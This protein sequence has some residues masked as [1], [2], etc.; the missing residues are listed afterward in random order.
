MRITRSGLR[1]IIAEEHAR[2]LAEMKAPKR[3]EDKTDEDWA[4]EQE[5]GVMDY[6]GDPDPY[7]DDEALEMGYEYDG[8]GGWI[9][10]DHKGAKKKAWQVA[11]EK[12]GKDCL[13]VIYGGRSVFYV[14][15]PSGLSEEEAEA[16]GIEVTGD[17]AGDEEMANPLELYEFLSDN[18]FITAVH[19]I[20]SAGGEVSKDAFMEQLREVGEEEGLFA[21]DDDEF[22]NEGEKGKK[23]SMSP[24]EKLG[25]FL[26]KHDVDAQHI[27]KVID[28]VVKHAKRSGE[29]ASSESVTF[30]L[31]DE[32]IEALPEDE[33]D[34][35]HSML[36]A[37]LN[38][39]I[40]RSEYLEEGEDDAL[41]EYGDPDDSDP[42]EAEVSETYI[43][44]WDRDEEADREEDER[45]RR[46]LEPSPLSTVH[47]YPSDRKT[48]DHPTGLTGMV[49]PYSEY[50]HLHYG[51]GINEARWAKLAGILKG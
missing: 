41:D 34:A 2:I 18:D 14:L 48:S 21:S 49:G 7:G 26:A 47:T 5:Q 12:G 13:Y 43:S 8:A 45:I 23:H 38:D 28:A 4:E 44:H 22:V 20:E 3:D 17:I 15:A 35:W 32:I 19:D 40:D 30:N 29:D 6:Y 25:R 16:E 42:D 36:D 46:S 37:V 51:A 1:K 11:A 39:E 27:Y 24:R 31:P 9:K 33:A 10:P 50:D